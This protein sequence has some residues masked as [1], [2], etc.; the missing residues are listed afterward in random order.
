MFGLLVR[1]KTVTHIRLPRVEASSLPDFSSLLIHT[2]GHSRWWLRWLGDW[3]EL[4][5][6]QLGPGLALAISGI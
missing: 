1:K 5:L 2:L 3:V 6:S 4:P